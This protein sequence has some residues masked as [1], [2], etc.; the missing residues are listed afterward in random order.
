MNGSDD[1]L[2]RKNGAI[3]IEDVFVLELE[4]TADLCVV[5]EYSQNGGL[6]SL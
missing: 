5:D 2:F 1:G 6:E 4:V 3:G